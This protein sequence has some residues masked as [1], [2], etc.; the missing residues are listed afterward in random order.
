MECWNKARK[1][2]SSGIK[3][4]QVKTWLSK[5]A[6]SAR[7]VTVKN[8]ELQEGD[9]V[10]VVP[11]EFCGDLVRISA[12]NKNHI[13][14]DCRAARTAEQVLREVNEPARKR[15]ATLNL[16][17]RYYELLQAKMA[18]RISGRGI[19]PNPLSAGPLRIDRRANAA[20][21]EVT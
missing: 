8:V 16:V 11:C 3:C 13:L 18:R 9:F 14:E 12:E 17:D 2:S 6:L 20:D 5:G 1:S 10:S 19:T 21:S 4:D 15:P 7:A